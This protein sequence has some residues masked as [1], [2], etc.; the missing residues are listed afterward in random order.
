MGKGSLKKVNS[1]KSSVKKTMKIMKSPKKASTQKD[2]KFTKTVEL[3]HDQKDY[4]KKDA[5]Y[6]KW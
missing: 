1:K 4:F 2:S 3:Y 5:V 6:A